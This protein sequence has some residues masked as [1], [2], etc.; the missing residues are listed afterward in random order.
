MTESG[1]KP[2]GPTPLVEGE[3]VLL[4]RTEGDSWLLPLA[5]GAQVLDGVGVFDLSAAIGAPE[6]TSVDVGGRS[7][8]VFRPGLRDAV[9]HMKRRA[10][11][12]TPKDA[13]YLLYFAGVG[14]GSRV[15]EAGTGSG[16]LTLFLAHAVGPTGR[17]VSYDRRPEHQDVARG[18]LT[19]VGLV[20]RVELRV[21]DVATGFDE[22][23]V[24]AVLLDLPEPWEVVKAAWAALR[25]GGHLVTYV[26]TYNQLER[27]VRSMREAGFEEVRAVEL[28]ERSLHV[29]E[30]GTRPDFEMLGHTG[31]LAG[32]RRV[33]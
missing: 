6:G 19:R 28:L 14:P 17:V 7:Y 22:S 30:G 29:G 3:M 16:G 20:G 18:N 5:R 33:T 1:S 21:R 2:G 4:R 31:F 8:R 12:I 27:S 24:D 25:P 10:Q 9:G 13:Q 26:P 11:I 23:N 32:G 15:L